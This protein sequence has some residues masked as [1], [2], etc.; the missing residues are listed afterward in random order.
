MN[1]KYK[2]ILWVGY[3]VVCA[4]VCLGIL[5][6]VG[7]NYLFNN[8]LYFVNDLDHR[9]VPNSSPEINSDGIRSTKEGEDFRIEDENIIFLG[10]SFVYGWGVDYSSTI[11]YVLEEKLNSKSIGKKFNIA[12]FGWLSSS[13]LLSNRLLIDKGS[14]Y[15]PKW[16]FLGLD[17]SDFHDDLKY[18][19]VEERRGLMKLIDYLPITLLSTRKVLSNSD[20]LHELF[21]GFPGERFFPSNRPLAESLGFLEE[22]K[23][24]IISINEFCRKELNAQFVLFLFPRAYQYSE[25]ASPNS[26][27]KG[28]YEEMGKFSHETFKFFLGRGHEEFNFP[29]F[30]LLDDFMHSD[31]FPTTFD[32]DP[33]WNEEGNLIAAEAIFNYFKEINSDILER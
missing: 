5:E 13:P 26:W 32:D 22:T 4:S 16:V 1:K 12:N 7:Q 17:M 19:A 27:E 10:D 24:N 14:N 25:G 33:H 31:S 23:S 11:P 8:K 28:Q 6:Y 21:F 20:K 9:M 15:N 2:K 18:K 29:I 3:V 30:S